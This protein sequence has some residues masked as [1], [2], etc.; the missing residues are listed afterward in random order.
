MSNLKKN[1]VILTAEPPDSCYECP[2]LGLI[3]EGQ[4]DGKW[5][6]VC[7]A[8]G[9]ALTGRGIKVKVSKKAEAW[10]RLRSGRPFTIRMPRPATFTNSSCAT[11]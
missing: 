10:N 8:T 1:Q 9:D 11:G 2:M 7:C 3:P 4:R 5:T 6:H